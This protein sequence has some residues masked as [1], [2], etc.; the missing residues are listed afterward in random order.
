MEYLPNY[1]NGSIVNLMTWVLN[2]Y[3]VENNYNSLSLLDSIDSSKYDTIVNFVIDGLGYD[4]LTKYGKD[5]LISNN[6]IGKM[7]SVFPTTT[8]AAIS[9][10]ATGQA[11]LEHGITGWH[12]KLKSSKSNKSIPSLV[13]PYVSR[14]DGKPL[15]D[16]GILERDVFRLPGSLKGIPKGYVVLPNEAMDST[17]SVNMNSGAKKIGYDTLGG[18]FSATE[19]AIKGEVDGGEDSK[20]PSNGKCKYI[21]SYL[22]SFDELFHKEG[23]KSDNL[24]GLFKLLNKELDKF[25][26][27]IKGS[28]TLIILTADHGLLDTHDDKKVNL[29]D[30]KHIQDTLDFPLCGEPR[31]VYCYVKKERE[32]QFVEYIKNDFN[33]ICDLYT[34]EELIK[35][36]L[37]GLFGDKDSNNSFFNDRIGDYILMMK[38]HW[39]MKDFLLNEEIKFHKADHGGLSYEELHIPLT[40]FEV[41]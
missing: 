21:F 14:I 38:K 41:M 6:T 19:T 30:F 3:N 9:S 18:F 31:T 22:P 28:K 20:C 29:N 33:E 1:K 25:L 8:A 15:T 11:P 26:N 5:S 39:V 16:H 17:Y 13:I 23:E 4:Y 34:R 37:F 27:N 12:M 40:V 7:T 35:E 24:L 2:K 32:K 10:F 36:N